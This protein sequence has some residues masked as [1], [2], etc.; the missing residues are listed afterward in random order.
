[1][2]RKLT[3]LILAASLATTSMAAPA[4]ASDAD[5]IAK[6]LGVAATLF[7][8][9]KAIEDNS[10]QKSHKPA[11]QPTYKSKHDDWKHKDKRGADQSRYGHQGKPRGH[12]QAPAKTPLPNA[13]LTRVEGQG[14]RYAL[15]QRCLER[16]Y[17][18][19]RPLPSSC[20]IWVE[21]RHGGT[22]PA[23]SMNCLRKKG[24]ETDQMAR[25]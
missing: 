15:G 8:I 12:V 6:F 14:T 10:S 21:G 23:Y 22:R 13:C 5:D 17:Q 9:G 2:S 3:S 18:S 20:K 7:I 16:N 4:R 11:P 19:A 1:M 24:Y 25:R